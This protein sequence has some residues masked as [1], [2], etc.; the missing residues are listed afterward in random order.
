LHR[1]RDSCKKVFVKEIDR[2]DRLDFMRHLYSIGNEARTVYNLISI[3]QQW[4][5]EFLSRQNIEQMS[6]EVAEHSVKIQSSRGL[7]LLIRHPTQYAYERSGPVFQH[8]H[9]PDPYSGGYIELSKKDGSACDGFA[10]HR[11]P[12][13]ESESGVT[14]HRVAGSFDPA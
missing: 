1:S 7:T 11:E 14:W 9:C 8:C 3:V 13:L 12:I 4:L 6:I 10:L 2:N 5:P